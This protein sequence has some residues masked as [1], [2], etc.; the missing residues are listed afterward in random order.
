MKKIIF[1]CLLLLGV[2]SLLSYANTQ[3]VADNIKDNI[4][5]TS[6][7]ETIKVFDSKKQLDEVIGASVLRTFGKSS[8]FEVTRIENMELDSRFVVSTVFYNTPAGESTIMVV[9]NF[10]LKEKV[11]VDCTGT[12]DCRER[13]IIKPDGT[14]IYECTCNDCKM[15]KET[16]PNPQ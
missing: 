2:M 8:A 16:V 9:T 10:L 4:Y 7:G 15:T 6:T 11:I 14:E 3:P 13:L 12:C 5:T 1:S